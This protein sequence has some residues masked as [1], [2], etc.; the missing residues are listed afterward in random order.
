MVGEGEH[1]CNVLRLQLL[2]DVDDTAKI[3]RVL[4]R[5]SLVALDDQQAQCDWLTKKPRLTK[6][7]NPFIVIHSIVMSTRAVDICEVVQD[8]SLKR[9]C[10]SF[11]AF[12]GFKRFC[13]GQNI[14]NGALAG[15]QGPDDKDGG[16]RGGGY[17]LYDFSES[18]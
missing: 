5:G 7:F 18:S 3:Y 15:A 12:V 8:H 14:A 6:F 16:F 17:H 11:L 2:D 4:T 9:L 13:A 1:S 10:H